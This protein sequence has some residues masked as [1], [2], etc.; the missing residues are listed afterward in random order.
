MTFF[1]STGLFLIAQVVH[2][3]DEYVLTKQN[4]KEL[5]NLKL[6]QYQGA[7]FLSSTDEERMK[8]LERMKFS[9]GQTSTTVTPSPSART[10]TS[11]STSSSS[12]KSNYAA[13]VDENR[14]WKQEFSSVKL[15]DYDKDMEN[16][17]DLFYYA[18]TYNAAFLL[19]I[20][21]FY[22]FI[23]YLF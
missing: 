17:A 3:M 14:L 5:K 13:L 19:F 15:S 2:T 7:G 21:H 11:D 22:L 10:P 18:A 6:R 16:C 9:Q 12:V 20:R 1:G 8:T 23:Y 4:R